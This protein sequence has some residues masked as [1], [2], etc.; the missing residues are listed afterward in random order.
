MLGNN[1]N[2]LDWIIKKCDICQYENFLL[3][4]LFRQQ[5]QNKQEKLINLKNFKKLSLGIKSNFM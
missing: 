2:S 5:R 4:Y 1:H 3:M